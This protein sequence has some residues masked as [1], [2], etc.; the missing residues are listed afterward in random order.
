VI[1]DTNALSG[2]ADGDR[3]LEPLLER[4]DRIAIPAIVLGEWRYGVLQSRNRRRYEQWLR[5]V[6]AACRVLAVDEDTTVLTPRC[7]TS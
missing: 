5:E 6:I 7:A 2:L 1:L 4:A 3:K